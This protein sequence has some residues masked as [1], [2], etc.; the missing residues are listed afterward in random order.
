MLVDKARQLD[1]RRDAQLPRQ[2]VRQIEHANGDPTEIVIEND[3]KEMLL[4]MFER[5]IS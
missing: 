2:L 5:L 3:S 1:W 4:R